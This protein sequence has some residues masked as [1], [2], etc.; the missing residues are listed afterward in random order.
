MYSK[1]LSYLRPSWVPVYS[2]DTWL[3]SIEKL[4]AVLPV[5]L[6]L[7]ASMWCNIEGL[8]SYRWIGVNLQY[9]RWNRNGDIKYCG[10]TLSHD[11]T[12]YVKSYQ[13][14]EIC[15]FVNNLQFSLIWTCIKLFCRVKFIFL[16]TLYG[17]GILL[18]S[19]FHIFIMARCCVTSVNLLL[20]NAINTKHPLV[21]QVSIA[22]EFR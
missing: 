12:I 6:F 7:F 15:K 11:I 1:M 22:I 8:K 3:W 20:C 18:Q 17:L 21:K 10:Y 16:S 4:N 5:Q 19:I 2:G 9:H 13:D 14:M